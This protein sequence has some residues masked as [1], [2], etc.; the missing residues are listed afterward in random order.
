MRE[1]AYGA[2][3]HDAT[4]QAFGPGLGVLLHREVEGRLVAIGSRNRAGGIATVNSGPAFEQPF[5]RIT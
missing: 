5:R 3:R 1:R 4:A 2:G